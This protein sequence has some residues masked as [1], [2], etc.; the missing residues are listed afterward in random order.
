MVNLNKI[1]KNID[2]LD[3]NLS[4]EVEPDD[5][6]AYYIDIEIK[7]ISNKR[8]VIIP[9]IFRKDGNAFA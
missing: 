9:H 6:D 3:L 1:L 7:Q 4:F 5:L 8:K 2:N